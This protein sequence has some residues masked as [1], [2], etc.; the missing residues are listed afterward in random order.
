[1]PFCWIGFPDLADW[2]CDV[3]KELVG[4]GLGCG[5]LDFGWFGIFCCGVFGFPDLAVVGNVKKE[6][7]G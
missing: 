4:G 1:M 6:L 5:G 2:G 3:S 7:V